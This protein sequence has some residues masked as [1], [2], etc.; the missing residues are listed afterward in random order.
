MAKRNRIEGQ[1]VIYKT[2]DRKLKIEQHEL[3]KKL[4]YIQRNLSKPNS[5]EPT[6]VFRIDMC[7]VYTG[8]I[9]KDFLH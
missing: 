6:G 4:T 3:H 5:M 7:S 9:N 2:L 1:K 8:K